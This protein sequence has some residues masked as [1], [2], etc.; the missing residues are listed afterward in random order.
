MDPRPLKKKIKSTISGGK[1][2]KS[3]SLFSPYLLISDFS[4]E[5]IGT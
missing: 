2:I 5:N 1:S 3:I 4:F